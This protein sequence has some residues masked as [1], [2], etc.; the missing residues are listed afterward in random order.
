MSGVEI[1]GFVLA[2]I[3]L[4]ISA[5]EH[6]KESAEVLEGWWKVKSEWRKCK[7]NLNYHKVAFEENLEEL[8]L[9]LIADEE[10]LKH[11]LDCPGGPEWRDPTLEEMLRE[12]MPK[13]YSAYLETIEEMKEV[14]EGLDNA[15]GMN[16]MHFQNRVTEEYQIEKTASNGA[17]SIGHVTI[18]ANIEY[19]TQRIKLAFN[20]TT[21]QELFEEFGMYNARLRDILGSSDRLAALRRSRVSS[22]KAAVINSGLWKFWSHANS[23]FDLL[24]EAWS[25]KCQALHHANL[26]LQHRVSSTVNFRVVFWYKSH[27]EGGQFPWTWQDASIELL[28]SGSC[29]IP[30]ILK[31]PVIQN[32]PAKSGML[33]AT[34]P[35]APAAIQD[36]TATENQ[37]GY[38]KSFFGKWK[39][40]KGHKNH[41]HYHHNRHHK[42]NWSKT[43]SVSTAT[44]P[45]TP[46]ITP[47][48]PKVA[49]IDPPPPATAEIASIPKITNLCTII[50]SSRPEIPYGLLTEGTHQYLIQPLQAEIQPQKYIKL[51]A[52]LSK[53]STTT[54][55]RRQRYHIALILASSHIQLHPTPWLTSK[56]SKTDILFL[57]SAQD[58]SKVLSEQPYISR[59]LSKGLH[60]QPGSQAQNNSISKT[61]TF[62][63]SIRNLGIMLLE[64]CFGT[65]IED[66]KMRQNLNADDEQSLQLINYAVAIQWVRDVV[67]E[68]GPE[69]ADAVTWCLHNV[70]ES[71]TEERWREDMFAAVVEKLKYCYDQLVGV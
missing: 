8:L 24:T 45:A 63:D 49:F 51:E 40:Q 46:L 68:A 66:H 15:L 19:Q 10:K 1:A 26:L 21:R 43:A 34:P 16:K 14:V 53:S 48:K 37:N 6:Y 61:Y 42:N 54:L 27:L 47:A 69:Y 67:E 65:A 64:L 62:Q 36:V 70:P 2:A 3:P 12:R 22:K 13:T 71:G 31:V 9:P 60:Y 35:S 56:W 5:L 52:I 33:P 18:V 32:A 28:E 57:H 41:H 38:Q 30:I 58:P 17:K 44:S 7:N 25:C 59:S 11:L 39:H 4:M 20:K 55:S 50:A 29:Q 23:V